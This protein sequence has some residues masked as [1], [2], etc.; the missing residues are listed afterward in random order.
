MPAIR[1]LGPLEVRVAGRELSVP[2]RNGPWLLSGLALAA[3]RPVPEDRL[4]EWAWG[5]GGASV[6]ALRT[7]ISRIR[8]WLRDQMALTDAI[9]LTGH[10]Y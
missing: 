3:G 10:G 2:G 1:V 8:A 6:G 5:P 7:G 9:E 4:V